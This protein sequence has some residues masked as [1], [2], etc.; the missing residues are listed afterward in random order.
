MAGGFDNP[1][2]RR[3]D[4]GAVAVRI[5]LNFVWNSYRKKRLFIAKTKNHG[6]GG[7]VQIKTSGLKEPLN[8]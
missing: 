5:S 4:S 1:G 8:A 7:S 6:T 2:K 3:M